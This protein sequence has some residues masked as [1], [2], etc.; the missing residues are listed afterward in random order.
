MKRRFSAW[1]LLLSAGWLGCA[2]RPQPEFSLPQADGQEE[3]S[4]R[5]EGFHMTSTRGGI[6][7]WDF[8]GR[9]AKI[10]EKVNLARIQ[11]MR[12][13][14]WRGGKI[15]SVLTARQGL[16]KTDVQDVRAEGNVCMVSEEGAIL[17][18]ERLDW[19]QK[20]NKLFTLS[21]VTVVKGGNILNGVGLEADAD[22]R[23]LKILAQVKIEVRSVREIERISPARPGRTAP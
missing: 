23:H 2:G 16:V 3:P 7:E 9:L 5:F 22:L 18:T 14:Y 10:Y 13:Q 12:I 11:D 21:P 15:A 8:T 19:N 6:A 20:R 1:L 4:I 17:R